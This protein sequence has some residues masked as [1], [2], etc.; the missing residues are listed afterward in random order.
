ML[1]DPGAGWFKSRAG[2]YLRGT[3]VGHGDVPVKQC[4]E[5]LKRAGYNGSYSIEFEGV[6]ENVFAL[7][8][9]FENLN[10]YFPE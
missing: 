5:T 8:T 2:N 10:R 3:I 4:I 7:K 1:P 6:E 9:G